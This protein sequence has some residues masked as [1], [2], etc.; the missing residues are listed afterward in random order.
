MV[1]F[2]VDA[3]DFVDFPMADNAYQRN[4]GLTLD[5]ALASVEVFAASTRSPVSS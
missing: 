2:D 5:D 1:H 4:Q 3:L